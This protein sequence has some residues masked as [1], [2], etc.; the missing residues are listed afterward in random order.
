MGAE[1]SL[2]VVAEKLG[3]S[4]AAVALLS[5]RHN[6]SERAAYW[7]QNVASAALAAVKSDSIE[8]ERL[9]NLRLQAARERRWERLQKAEQLVDDLLNKHLN[10]PAADIPGYALPQL[11]KAVSDLADKATAHVAK[12]EQ[13][14][15]QGA[16]GAA[17]REYHN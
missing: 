6:W 9:W 12:S 1:A 15:Q 4:Y 16:S 11:V 5:S 7:R 2:K 14:S 8:H 10:N 17:L 13:S 3:R